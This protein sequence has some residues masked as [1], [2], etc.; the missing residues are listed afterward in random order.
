[1]SERIGVDDALTEFV[2]D[3]PLSDDGCVVLIGSRA[4]GDW[5]PGSD[6]D[7]VFIDPA[8]DGV[9]DRSERIDALSEERD[10][11]VDRFLYTPDEFMAFAS[12]VVTLQQGRREP[13]VSERFSLVIHTLAVGQTLRG[14][15]N[16]VEFRA[17]YA[18]WVAEGRL[19]K[20][21]PLRFAPDLADGLIDVQREILERP[22]S[23]PSSNR[24]FRKSVVCL[25]DA[26]ETTLAPSAHRSQMMLY[27]MVQPFR[28][29]YPLFETVGNFGS[30][31]GDRPAAVRYTE[32]R[33]RALLDHGWTLGTRRPRLEPLPETRDDPAAHYWELSRSGVQGKTHVQTMGNWKERRGELH[34]KFIRLHLDR[35][36]ERGETIA[37]RIERLEA[38]EV[39]VDEKTF[40]AAVEGGA[41]VARP[42]EDRRDHSD[43]D[44]LPPST[45]PRP[46]LFPVLLAN[47]TIGLP[48]VTCCF[49][50]H[51]LEGIADAL[52][53]LMRHPN[54]SDEALVDGL[55]LP[56]FATGGRIVDPAAAR[57]AQ[58]AGRGD[59]VVEAVFELGENEAGPTVTL[60]EVPPEVFLRPVIRAFREAQTRGVFAESITFRDD[61]R[62]AALRVEFQLEP[63]SDPHDFQAALLEHTGLRR[64]I[65]IDMHGYEADEPVRTNSAD[66]VRRSLA[67][68]RS[69]LTDEPEVRAAITEL[70]RWSDPRRTS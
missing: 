46:L 55:G 27:A 28:A 17:R 61:S 19:P 51:L 20:V 68:H 44:R 43:R 8:F 30:L 53:E 22:E 60:L 15:E 67:R 23:R 54:A 59:V 64:T 35:L 31:H 34:A 7:L 3:V 70:R 69:V 10:L 29:R 37:R 42:D 65:T 4:R 5:H 25:T 21:E 62:A 36:R 40:W 39:P 52:T 1:M 32:L 49:P 26:S 47:G 38:L 18:Q 2:R 13:H 63:G 57:E 33:P 11:N 66:L 48:G 12:A 41:E 50:P 58:L 45:S 56:D 6:Y 24:N 14:A 9:A 16:F